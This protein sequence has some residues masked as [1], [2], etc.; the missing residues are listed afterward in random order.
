MPSRRRLLTTVPVLAATAAIAA[1]STALATPDHPVPPPTFGGSQGKGATTDK[2]AASYDAVIGGHF[3]C[4]GVRVVNKGAGT[5]DSETCTITDL[6]S[7]PPGT[8]TVT[9]G[10]IRVKAKPYI[11]QSD[12]DGRVAQSGTITVVDN[13][14]GTGTLT[15]DLFY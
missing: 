14:N 11:W 5:Q 13:G 4:T 3:T 2:F 9:N 6:S 10:I 15:L 8:Y 1:P 7:F 12:Y